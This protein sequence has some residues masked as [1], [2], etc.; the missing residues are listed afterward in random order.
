MSRAR[1]YVGSKENRA[2]I[3]C[4]ASIMACLMLVLSACGSHLGGLG[5]GPAP[6]STPPAQVQKCGTVRTLHAQI[7]PADQKTARQAAT[8]FWQT[9]QRCQPPTPTSAENGLTTATL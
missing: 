2:L 4:S 9:F 7:V 1:R 8:C 6:T 3:L 5:Q